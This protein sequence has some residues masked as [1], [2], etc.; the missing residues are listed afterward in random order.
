MESRTEACEYYY[1]C[2]PKRGA[3]L[4]LQ[5]FKRPR[6]LNIDLFRTL[7]KQDPKDWEQI[8]NF[9]LVPLCYSYENHYAFQL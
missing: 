1:S 3:R 9:S 4:P 5:R 6:C 2:G 7:P 8:K